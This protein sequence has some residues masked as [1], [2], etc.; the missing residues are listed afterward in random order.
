MP[1]DNLDLVPPLPWSNA[2]GHI[3]ILLPLGIYAPKT[4]TLNE[5]DIACTLCGR[6]VRE[7]RVGGPG[8][9]CPCQRTPLWM[10]DYA[11]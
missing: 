3:P 7:H 9:S 6:P 11:S 8:P 2:H 4:F 1:V 5:L 10:W